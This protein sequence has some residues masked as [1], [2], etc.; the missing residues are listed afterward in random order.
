MRA[1]L[2]ATV[3]KDGADVPLDVL[4]QLA[5]Q[6]DDPAALQAIADELERRVAGA[7]SQD[8]PT[9]V[10]LYN[11]RVR[12][13]DTAGA[14][15]ARE[16]IFEI[17]PTMANRRE[18]LYLYRSEKRWQDAADLVKDWMELADSKAHLRRVY[19]DLLSR[20][21]RLDQVEEQVDQMLSEITDKEEYVQLIYFA[22]VREAAWNL[23]DAGLDDGA[24]RL[25]RRVAALNP[26]DQEALAALLHFYGSEEELALLAAAESQKWADEDDPHALFE[27]GTARLTAGDAEGAFPLLQRAAPG[28]PNLEPAWYN[29]GMAAY[30]VENWETVAKAFGRAGELNDSRPHT[31]LYRGLA[32][33]KL[34]RCDQAVVALDRAVQLDPSLTNAHYYLASCYRWLGRNEDA[35]RHRKLYQ[36]SQ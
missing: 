10:A 13:D 12:Q 5:S 19:I 1:S 36:A 18:L 23:R 7:Q 22:A 20:L 17:E 14:I 9:L 8:R 24:E 35:A 4:S 34:G 26:K 21:N 2:I 31:F 3:T 33:E 15:E 16:K 25:F 32:L 28:L 6:H 11:L 30:R 27:E 29:L